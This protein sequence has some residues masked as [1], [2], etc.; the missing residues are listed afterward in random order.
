MHM[1]AME[2]VFSSIDL[3]VAEYEMHGHQFS[4]ST[5]RHSPFIWGSVNI[6]SNVSTPG[7]PFAAFVTL[8]R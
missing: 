3:M 8:M 6:P 7:L 1:P 4:P 5:A 2:D